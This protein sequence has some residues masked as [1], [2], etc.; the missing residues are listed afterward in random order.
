MPVDGR[1]HVQ[2]PSLDDESR[3]RRTKNSAKSENDVGLAPSAV[4]GF[5][6]HRTMASGRP[7]DGSGVVMVGAYLDL[8]ESFH[9]HSITPVR[10]FVPK[11][12]WWATASRR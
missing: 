8:F 10:R 6:I 5:R 1:T 2:C 4:R 7:G 9:F 11:T 3:L 12:W